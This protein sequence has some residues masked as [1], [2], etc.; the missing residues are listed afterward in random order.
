MLSGVDGGQEVPREVVPLP[1]SWMLLGEDDLCGTGEPVAGLEAPMEVAS[2][3]LRRM[4]F[5]KE[6]LCGKGGLVQAP[7]QD[8]VQ[9]LHRQPRPV[10]LCAQ[11]RA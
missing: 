6:D 9:L 2:L 11:I 10:E 1:L 3:S 4:L 7:S 5:G 8:S